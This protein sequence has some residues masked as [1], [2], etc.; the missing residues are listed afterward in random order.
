MACV[1]L[2]SKSE[3]FFL[4]GKT[5]LCSTGLDSDIIVEVG[6]T[7]FHLH[8]MSSLIMLPTLVPREMVSLL[9]MS[10][11]ARLAS[12]FP[13]LAL[14]IL[15]QKGALS[16]SCFSPLPVPSNTSVES[17]S[18]KKPSTRRQL[19]VSRSWMFLRKAVSFLAL[20]LTIT[21]LEVMV[22][23]ECKKLVFMVGRRW[24][25]VQRTSHLLQQILM[26][27]RSFSLKKL[28]EIFT[29]QTLTRKSYC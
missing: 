28:L 25:H 4:D 21:L 23:H 9:L 2:G 12:V 19:L 10:Q 20:R 29:A 7:S 11:L 24:S 1:K 6:E 5:W 8:K 13:A 26:D 15:R 18:L 17:F 3:V 22:A 27:E 14:R 16:V